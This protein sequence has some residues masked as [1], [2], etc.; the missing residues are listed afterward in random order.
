[1]RPVV[2]GLV[3]VLSTVV[4][5]FPVFDDAPVASACSSNSDFF[6]EAPVVVRGVVTGWDY[7]RD[8]SGMPVETILD[9]PQYSK[10][11]YLP[12][13]RNVEMTANVS[14]VFKGPVPGRIV[15]DTA[16]YDRYLQAE[17]S[18]PFGYWAWPGEA[19]ACFALGA[20]PTGLDVMMALR[21]S[22]AGGSYELIIS[23]F[24]YDDGS[25]RAFAERFPALGAP[26]PPAVGNTPP[27]AEQPDEWMFV[28]A[29]G[30]G[31]LLLTLVLVLAGPRRD[32]RR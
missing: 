22:E 20:D 13:K 30:G 14:A 8:A 27:P 5:A 2:V 23:P 25:G 16:H 15:I 18:P 32:R 19:G 12:H 7:E 24:P 17:G 29:I 28:S 26:R 10:P 6:A 31:C 4:A 9:E 1:M 11:E 3:V 21:P